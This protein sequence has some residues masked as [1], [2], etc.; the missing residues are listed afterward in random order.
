MPF[1]ERVKFVLEFVKQLR[2]NNGKN[3]YA[4]ESENQFFNGVFAVNGEHQTDRVIASHNGKGGGV[5]R[6]RSKAFGYHGY[7]KVKRDIVYVAVI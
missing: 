7:N 4:C 2:R 6:K 3:R 5:A 1:S